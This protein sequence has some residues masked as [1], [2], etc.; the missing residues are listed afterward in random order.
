MAAISV[1]LLAATGTQA[2]SAYFQ[3][4]TNLNPIVYFPLQETT[5]PPIGDVETNLGSLGPVGDAVYSSINAS[6]SGGGAT[7]DGDTAVQ[8]NGNNGGFLAVPI[9]NP[10]VTLPVG[11]F[12]VEA[13]VYPNNYNREGIVSQTGP[14]G[15]GGVR[16][17]STQNNSSGWSLTENDVPSLNNTTVGW[18]FHVYN[19][20]G[21]TGPTNG[22]EAYIITPY[23]IN[24]WY[25]IVGVFDGANC[26]LYIDG[27]N[28]DSLANATNIINHYSMTGTQAQD[29]WDPLCIGC[30]RGLNNNR[31]VGGID[32]VAIYTNVLTQ[33]E[34]AAHYAAASSAS[35]YSTTILADNPYM[36]WRMN[37]PNYTAP[38]TSTYPTAANYGS[39]T[40]TTAAGNPSSYG[41]ATQPGVPGPQFPGML[42]PNN[43]NA[44][45]AVAINGIGGTANVN[46]GNSATIADAVPVEAGMDSGGLLYRTNVGSI[47]FSITIWF[48][49]NPADSDRF[50]NLFGHSDSGWRTAIDSSG[51]VHFKPGNSGTEI[52]SAAAYNDGNWHQLVVTCNSSAE[53]MY[54]D[55]ILSASSGG[56]SKENGSAFDVIIGG[57]PQYLNCGNGTY[58]GSSGSGYAQRNFDGSVCQFAFFTNA[59]SATDVQNLYSAVKAPP[60]IVAQPATGRVNPS[61]AY[62]YF[63]VAASGASPLSYQWYFN[64]SSNYD[65]ATTLV[66]DNVK[67]VGATTFQVT[68]S[69]LVDSDSG[70]YFVVITNNYGSVTSSLATLSVNDEPIITAQSPSNSFTLYQGQSE[71]FSVTV[72]SDAASQLFYQWFTNGVA[73]PNGTN[74]SYVS[75]TAPPA[76]AGTTYQCIVTNDFGAATNASVSLLSVLPLPAKPA[77]LTSSP[78]GSSILAL[79]PTAYWPMHET[80]PPLAQRDIETNYGAIGPIADAYYGD[81][82]VNNGDPENSVV[83]HQSPGALAGDSNPSVQFTSQGGSYAV[84]PRTSPLTTI[85]APF[86]LEAWVKPYNN[87]FGIILGV[88]DLTANHGLNSGASQGGFDWLWAGSANTFSITMRNG[89]GTSSTEPKTTANYYPGQWYHLVTTFDGTNVAYYINGVQDYLQNSSAATMAPN[90]WEP[91]TIGGGRWTGGIHNQ[92]LGAI[93]ELAVY[94]NLLDPSRITAHYT[95]GITGSPAY[96]NVVLADN[97]LLFYRMDSPP[98]TTPSVSAWP[99]LTNYGT[100]GVQG[101]YTPNATPGIVA[102]PSTPD[103]VPVVGL[104]ADTALQGDGNSIFADA[105]FDP[106]FNPQGTTP[107]TVAAWMKGNP[108]DDSDRNWQA[109]VA[110]SDS[111]WRLNINGGNGRANFNSGGSGGYDLGNITSTPNLNDGNWHYVVGTYDGV[112]SS[113]YVD[114]QLGSTHAGSTALGNTMVDVFLGAYPS[115]TV[116]GDTATS[117]RNEANR[118]LAGNLCEAAFWNGTALSSNQIVSLYNA[119]EVPPYITQQPISTSWNGNI[120]FTNSVLAGGSD[121]LT[122]Q[123]YKNGAPVTDDVNGGTTNTLIILSPKAF[124]TSTNYYVVVANSYGSVTSAPVSLLVI[125]NVVITQDI[126]N[127]NVTLFAGGH[128]TFSIMAAG[129]Q[130][131]NYQWYSNSVAIAGAT[132][133]TYALTNAQPPNTTNDYFCVATNFFGPA[134]SSAAMVTIIPDPTATYPLAVMA[135]NPVGFWRL[136]EGPDN[137]P[138]DG[139]VAHDYWGGND[140]IYTN[141]D[142]A[143]PGYNPLTE[144]TET[145]AAFGLQ[146]FVDSDVFAIP[147]NVDFAKPANNSVAFSIEAW[148]NGYQQT[149][150]AGIVS[151]G[152]GGGGEQFDLDCGANSTN[153]TQ[154]LT[155]NFRFFVRGA[156]GT[157]YGANSFI[158]PA[159]QKWHYLAAVC[160]EPDG[161]V[162]LYIDGVLV[163]TNT[164]VPTTAG[165]LASTRTM[166][167]GS[168]PSNSTTNVNDDQFVGSIDDVAVYNYAL[169]STQVVN[170]FISAARPATIQKQPT[171]AIAGEGG[172]ATFSVSV[173]GTPP[174][175]NQW[176]LNSSPIPGATNT[177]LV[178]TDVQS[179]DNGNSYYFTTAN[180]FNQSGPVQSATVTLN[181]VSGAPQIYGDVQNPFFAIQGGTG[182]NSVTAYG[183]EPL[184]YQWQYSSDGGATWGNLADVGGIT[185]S[186]SNILA[187][188]NAQASEAGDYQVIVS[189]GSGSVTSSPAL[190]IIGTLPIGFNINGSGWTPNQAGTYDTPIVT[191]GLVTLTESAYGSESRSFFFNYPQYI[192]AFKAAFTYQSS[193]NSGGNIADGASFC[194]QNDSRGATAIGGG[195]GSLGVAGITPSWELEFNIYAPNHVGYSVNNNGTIGPNTSTGSSAD[196]TN[197]L[198]SGDPIGVILYYDGE[199]LSMTLTDAVVNVSFSTNLDVGS[200]PNIVGGDTAYVGFTGADGGT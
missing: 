190:F 76:T 171:N 59:L 117:V 105:G 5:Q 51:L 165:I 73:D 13:W 33:A 140:G 54:V 81:W 142:L 114:G 52:K 17:S 97:P 41:T 200:L 50:Q 153:A 141:T 156:N 38:D 68:V 132:S 124:D 185:G 182:Y 197:M 154:S 107:F 159:D 1:V 42:D 106:A 168:R 48:K 16:G 34:I 112:N 178:L 127:T 108:A 166:L 91:L 53:D 18:A 188:A 130:P 86:T 173:E 138:N 88:G 184:S 24:Q 80:E 131:I 121:T 31:F 90:T 136:S 61:P 6:K 104:G 139:V 62:L 100:V 186:Q 189:N 96:T 72:I 79:N 187:I 28:I 65:G 145:A 40:L 122:Y 146:S 45:Y 161:M 49:C 63:G 149:A 27:T 87:S 19:G 43:V 162:A 22:A 174:L 7:A 20:Q 179:T 92:F 193:G 134:A 93:D 150:D 119:S 199:T 71:A 155:H 10:G 126:A 115:G 15:S 46:I 151:K 69:N 101:V 110:H 56:Q 125:T 118:M 195:G 67:Y 158:N 167:I 95:A 163:A 30:G 12:T 4:M 84:I 170:H 109:I 103:G 137:Y 14:I 196:E 147:T 78:F 198:A 25:H 85:Q 194:L 180:A 9:A 11:P 128:T 172:T 135:D 89:S 160:D 26:Q 70:Y 64:A 29:T 66:D 8:C 144:P 98:Y 191:N 77:S 123:W 99:V 183:T 23:A 102:G 55:G 177:T 3:A 83:V 36:Y 176:Y 129:A 82:K 35:P 32:E 94:T 21:S 143:Q 75:A 133:A 152:Y 2:Q 164:S 39:V 148:V 157:V 192:G 37:S 181:V 169:T 175:T 60:V 74:A 116:Y 44:S 120:P 111:G 47:P 58:N 113:V 57:D